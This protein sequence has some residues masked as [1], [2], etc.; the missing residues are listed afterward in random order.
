M[1]NSLLAALSCAALA[2]AVAAPAVAFPSA[3][4]TAR[5]ATTDGI[6]DADLQ[7]FVA[8]MESVRPIAAAAGSAPT[9]EQQIEMGAAIEASG[10]TIDRFNAISTAVASDPLMRA[11]VSLVASPPSPAGSV[12]ATVTDA[13]VEQFVAAMA[14]VRPIAESMNGATPTPEQQAEMVTAIEAAGFELD[15]FNA[16]SMAVPEDAHLRARLAVAEARGNG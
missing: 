5:L 13:E 6:E 10:L 12:A 1:R 3:T 2:T 9:A 11:R 16:I 7:K 15:R 8:A 4:P 14:S